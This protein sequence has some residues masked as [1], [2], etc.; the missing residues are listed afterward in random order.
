MRIEYAGT[1]Y[2]V[3][4]R[5]NYSAERFWGCGAARAFEALRTRKPD[6]VGDT[7]TR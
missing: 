7:S 2:H 3:I 6:L 1:V 4:N 5:G